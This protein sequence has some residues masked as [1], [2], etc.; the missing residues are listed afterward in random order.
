MRQVRT[1][2]SGTR[3]L[4]CL[5]LA[6]FALAA[7]L[8]AQDKPAD[9]GRPELPPAPAPAANLPV[10]E[11][12]E[13][14]S[15]QVVVVRVAGEAVVLRLIGVYLPQSGAAPDE[16]RSYLARL[17]AGE[18]V[19]VEFE[20]EWPERDLGERRWAYVFRAPDGLFVNVE[21]I[22][23]GFARVSGGAPYKH[24]RVLR[25]YERHARGL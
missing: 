19:Q 13:V 12:I 7:P 11:V 4:G 25:A 9:A 21:L 17:L 8:G 14:Q 24:E 1:S 6:A 5:V 20:P 23:Q 18:R 22:R 16:A 10:G 2:G 3:H 15:A